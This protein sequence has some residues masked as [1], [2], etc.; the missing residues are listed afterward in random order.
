MQQILDEAAALLKQSMTTVQDHVLLKK[1]EEA[2]TAAEEEGLKERR[3][4]EELTRQLTSKRLLAEAAEREVELL[5][6]LLSERSHNL[7]LLD[8]LG[9]D[10]ESL[11]FAPLATA[12]TSTR[13]MAHQQELARLA[14]QQ[15]NYDTWFL[16]ADR[17]KKQ[18][19]CCRCQL[20]AN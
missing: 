20:S 7:K 5:K 4:V 2:A 19:T 17:L 14:V 16:E 12:K 13:F 6:Q 9:K 15:G 18:P 10:S 3:E 1:L 8:A 11:E